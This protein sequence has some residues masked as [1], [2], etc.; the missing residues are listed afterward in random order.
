ML[1]EVV[2]EEEDGEPE[3]MPPRSIRGSL[4][5]NEVDACIVKETG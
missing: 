4:S 2:E 3:Y 1:D 5:P